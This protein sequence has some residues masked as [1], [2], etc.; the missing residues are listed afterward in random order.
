MKS[1]IKK[2]SRLVKRE[3]ALK[4]KI[5]KRRRFKQKNKK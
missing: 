5:K 3:K 2:D 4:N 1:L